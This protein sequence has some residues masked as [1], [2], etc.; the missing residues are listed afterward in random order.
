MTSP[1]AYTVPIPGGQLAF[2]EYGEGPPLLLLHS[3]Y[4]SHVTWRGQINPFAN[5][6]RLITCDLRGHGAS[7]V[8]P[9]RYSPGQFVEDVR[10]LID[11]LGLERVM[12]M[13]HGLGGI[14]AQELA[15]RIP[16]RLDALV[17]ADA[18]YAARAT[19]YDQ[20]NQRVTQAARAWVGPE[21]LIRRLNA[22]G[23]PQ[24]RD[25]VAREIARHSADRAN[26]DN[27]Y[28][29]LNGFD[30]R[31]MLAS[32]QCLSL[33]LVG[34]RSQSLHAHARFM[35]ESIRGSFYGVVLGAGHMLHWDNPALFNGIVLEFLQGAAA[36][37]A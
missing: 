23:S 29:M 30:H 17:I 9:E 25:Y 4:L 14:V 28:Q 32:I 20:L 16:S 31:E 6:F 18:P 37:N 7:S 8:T 10:R 34:E 19:F 36:L 11:W 5:H 15:I 2:Q 33:I 22:S 3:E 21:Y 24:F 26:F 35:N 27:I 12:V 1:T 13:G